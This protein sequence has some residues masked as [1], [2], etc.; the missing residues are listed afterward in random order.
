MKSY[1][2][3]GL[4]F[5]FS[6]CSLGIHAQD[7]IPQHWP[8]LDL[9]ENGIPGMSTEKAYR[10]LLV[11]K[12]NQTVI[13]AII[14]SGVDAE[15]ED[16]ADIMWVNPGEIAGNGIDDDGNGYIDDIHGWNFIG[17]KDGK[18]VSSENLEVVRLYNKG[19]VRFEGVDLSKLSKSAKKDYDN[20][21]AY[22]TEIEKKRTNLEPQ[23]DLYS[24]IFDKLKM[25]EKAVG[26]TADDV[27]IADIENLTKK[28]GELGE[29]AN[30][31]IGI[32]GRSDSFSEVYNDIKG[33]VNYF[34]DS[35]NHNWNP[36]F[37][38]RHLVGDNPADLNDRNYGNNETE[39]PDADHGTHVAGIVG[40]IRNN[41]IGIDGVANNVRI[42]SVRTVPNGDERDKDVANAIIYAVDNG[43]TIINMSFGKGHSPYKKAVDAALRYAV[44]NDVILVHAAGNSGRE[45]QFYNN[46]PN[47][48]FLKRGIFRPKH[49]KTW[50]EVG[51]MSGH[52]DENIT[53]S[54]SNWSAD[55][56]DVF[57]PGV[58]I[59]SSVPDSKYSS[60]NGTSM[61]APM[62][63]GLAALLRSYFP[64]LTAVQIKNII[65]ESSVNPGYKVNVPGEDGKVDFSKLC[66]TGGIVNTYTAVQLAIQTQGRK[67]KTQNRDTSLKPRA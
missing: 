26:K 7:A 57:A 49:A 48:V 60:F 40:A 56:V 25:V 63:A 18:N 35:Y 4:F 23:V 27:T 36:D 52:N 28:D 54:F 44:K 64:D 22:K 12:A 6:L 31:V 50:I 45:N 58:N 66:I 42:M 10:E 9:A 29:T 65:M 21:L 3:I 11:G 8:Q 33:T 19:K 5:A 43:A 38:A 2:L 20:Y 17:G 13:V 59:Y 53:A 41:D 46:Y 62:V 47:D 67:K 24:G 16:L 37:D 51:A 61:A 34:T 14:D 39:G 15:H 32:L 55:K 1:Y 30:Y